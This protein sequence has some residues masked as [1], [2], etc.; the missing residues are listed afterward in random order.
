MKCQTT[1]EVLTS[2][3]FYILGHGNEHEQCRSSI[4]E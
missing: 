3:W 2:W 1:W 4:K